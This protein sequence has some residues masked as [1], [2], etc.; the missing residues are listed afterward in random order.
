MLTEV[1]SAG[2]AILTFHPVNVRSPWEIAWEDQNEQNRTQLRL[3]EFMK[4]DKPSVKG[5]NKF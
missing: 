3:I 5:K 4:K 1:R 2:I